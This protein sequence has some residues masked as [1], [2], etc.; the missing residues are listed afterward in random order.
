MKW[1]V[2]AVVVVVILA[3]VYFLVGSKSQTQAPAPVPTTA[4]QASPTA[5]TQASSS[6]TQE[7]TITGKEF[8]FTPSTITAKVGQTVKITFKNNGTFP[9]NLTIADLNAKSDT[10]QPGQSTTFEVTPTKAGSF[11]FK[12]TVDSHAEKGMVGTLT[13]Q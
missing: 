10:I 7:V 8:A 5:A 4:A 9:H 11:E 6:A 2:I 1:A 12:C 3:G 13:V